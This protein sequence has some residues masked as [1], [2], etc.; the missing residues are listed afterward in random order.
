[1]RLFTF[2]AVA[3]LIAFVVLV[4]L[5]HRASPLAWL[6]RQLKRP[7][8]TETVRIAGFAALALA[9]CSL[10][11]C[12]GL[13]LASSPALTATKAD[14]GVD[15]L[16]DAVTDGVGLWVEAAHPSPA[17]AAKARTL[18]AQANAARLAADAAYA[19]GSGSTATQVAAFETLLTQV[20]TLTGQ[21]PPNY[22]AVAVAPASALVPAASTATAAPTSH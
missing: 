13:T 11:A 19:I 1:M 14:L 5:L 12:N 22:S 4:G 17:T 7:F 21:A 15:T 9:G 6:R 16:F 3:I 2:L 10:A 18:L 20:A 8:G